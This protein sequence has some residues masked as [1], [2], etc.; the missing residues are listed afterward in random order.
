[1]LCLFTGA[2][3]ALPVC[4]LCFWPP[5]LYWASRS[6]IT[7]AAQAW[8][9]ACDILEPGSPGLVPP[10]ALAIYI[11]W[12]FTGAA[13]ALLWLCTLAGSTLVLRRLAAA[14]SF[15]LALRWLF[16]GAALSWLP[17]GSAPALPQVCVF[18][19]FTLAL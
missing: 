6:C 11:C 9:C 3:L 17:A 12:L 1:M 18:H 13:L 4:S 15:F 14:T 19:S 8:C 2:A 7:G 5:L 10:A 16:P